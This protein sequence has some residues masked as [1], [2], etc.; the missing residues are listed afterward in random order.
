MFF[1]NLALSLHILTRRAPSETPRARLISAWLMPRS[2]I[3]SK[4]PRSFSPR[5]RV[6]SHAGQSSPDR[7]GEIRRYPPISAPACALRR[8]AGF[9]YFFIRNGESQPLRLQ[10]SSSPSQLAAAAGIPPAPRRPPPT[11]RRDVTGRSGVYR[12]SFLSQA[13]SLALRLSKY[14]PSFRKLSDS[15]ERLLKKSG[16]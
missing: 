11:R 2:Y 3:I 9:F 1:I 10:S 14:S 4:S 16:H 15:T 7:C 6:S 5:G 12:H 8:Q 13:R